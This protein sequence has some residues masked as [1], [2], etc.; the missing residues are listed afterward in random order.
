MLFVAA[1]ALP[2][3][4][5]GQATPPWVQATRQIAPIPLA[6]SVPTLPPVAL[7]K[8]AQPVDPGL[9][10]VTTPSVDSTRM[11]ALVAGEDLRLR[12]LL[13]HISRLTYPEVVPGSGQFD[14]SSGVLSSGVSTLVLPGPAN[15]T[16]ADLQSAGAVVPLTQGGFLLVDSVLVGSGATLT[17]GGTGLP[18][19][20][21]ES[22]SSGFTS[23]VTWG[24]TLSLYGEFPETPLT[25]MSWNRKTNM[26]ADE[27]TYGRPYIRAVGGKLD[28][29]NVHVSYL[30][31]W[32][33]RT[34]GVA[35]TGISSRA[36]TGTAT[37]ST[38]TNNTYGAFVSRSNNVQ[39]T[40]DLFQQNDLDGLRLH[41]SAIN[42]TVTG[43][44]AARNG[45]N[46]F[47]VSRGATGNAL[48]GD[49]AVNNGSNG[50]LIDGQS[51][52]R[53]AGPDGGQTSAS[54]G[55][56]LDQSDAENNART[57]ILVEGGAGTIVRNNIVCS[58]VTGIAVRQGASETFI[59][60]NEV[61]CGGRVA[62]SIGPDVS[63]TT[64]QGNLLDN[65]RIGMLIRNSPG[66]RLITNRVTQ[67]SVFGIS[68]RGLS[69]GIVGTDN[70]ISGRGFQPIDT[71]GGASTPTFVHTDITAWQH[72]SS[73]TFLGYLR[74]HPLITTWLIILVLVIV[75]SVPVRLRRRPARPYTYGVPW[76][77]A[78]ASSAAVARVPVAAAPVPAP[79]APAWPTPRPEPVVAPKPIPVA[80]ATNGILWRPF[81]EFAKVETQPAAVAAASTGSDHPANHTNTG[82]ELPDGR[83][84]S[85]RRPRKRSA[86]DLG[87]TT[88]QLM[89]AEPL[90]EEKQPEPVQA[91]V[92][93]QAEP[94][95]ATR[96]EK[97]PPNQFWNWLAAGSWAGDE[98]R[99][100]KVADQE[101]PA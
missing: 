11:A 95:P 86:E 26:P 24:G 82:E 33:G 7:S 62:L 9:A 28:L 53:G 68:V 80:A 60:G 47:V 6:T 64:V 59:V 10:P 44:A 71:R 101:S 13:H 51:L 100:G 48:H 40:D 20:L 67:M 32:S 35:W 97:S 70:F 1:A 14:V 55:T 88:Q 75:A 2:L 99:V 54:V 89:P 63:G 3:V 23:L 4:L 12:N 61:R 52:A 98:P 83:K 84:R 27:R 36:S 78:T 56:V 91:A 41:R 87:L 21:M 49:L 85:S 93:L 90:T 22:S 25:I 69:P 30:G 72:R 19:L 34:G 31:F 46:G 45:A 37:A 77:P 16:I 43:S 8:T 18:T 81:A 73:I 65:A 66:V 38:F 79:A 94:V 92:S 15:Y 50:F 58:S 74:Y 57:G 17:L 76:A 39:F 96:I 5:Q 42:S 29:R